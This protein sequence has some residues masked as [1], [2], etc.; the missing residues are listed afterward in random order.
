MVKKPVVHEFAATGA[1]TVSPEHSHFIGNHRLVGPEG[2][3]ADILTTIFI[4]GGQK[5]SQWKLDLSQA[6][7]DFFP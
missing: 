7:N 4:S 6:E 1:C 5:K 2:C 3:R